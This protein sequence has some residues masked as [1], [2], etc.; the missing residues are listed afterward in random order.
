[1]WRLGSLCCPRDHR[2]VLGGCGAGWRCQLPTH[3][4]W[5][6]GVAVARE[7]QLHWLSAAFQGQDWDCR[8]VVLVL[9]VNIQ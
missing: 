9:T 3:S 6:T 7:E 4:P 5:G 1:M 2:K 8:F